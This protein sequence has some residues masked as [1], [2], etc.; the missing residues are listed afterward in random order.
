MISRRFSLVSFAF[1]AA[2]ALALGLWF[3][4]FQRQEAEATPPLEDLTVAVTSSPP[5]SSTLAAGGTVSY[6]VTVSADGTTTTG[7]VPLDIYLSGLTLVAGSVDPSAG[8]A[9]TEGTP[10]DCTVTTVFS[11]AGSRSVDFQATVSAGPGPAQV[12]AVLDTPINGTDDGVLTEE[13]NDANAVEDL[14]DANL[15]GDDG[16]DPGLDCTA[17]QEGTDAGGGPVEEPDNFDCT[18]HAVATGFDLTLTQAAAPLESVT[19]PTG[20]LVSYTLTVANSG[21]GTA[22]NVPIRDTLGTGLTLFGVVPGDGVTCSDVGPPEINCTATSIPAGQSRSVIVSAIVSATTGSV[23]NGASVDPNNVIGETNDDADDD[24][25]SCASVGEGTDLGG[26]TEPDNFDCTSHAVGGQIDLTIT[27]TASPASGNSVTTGSTIS[28]TLTA[29]ATGGT[30]SNVVIR[31]TPGTGL[32]F[33][34]MA[35][36]SGTAGTGVTCTDTSGPTYECT[37]S[38]I[39]SGDSRSAIVTVTVSATTGTVLNGATVDPANTIPEENEDADDPTYDCSSVGEQGDSGTATEE[40]NFECTSHTVGAAGLDLRVSKTASPADGSS[41]ASGGTITYT[42]TVTAANAAASNVAIR[43][44]VGTGLTIT[45]VTPGSGVT[46]SDTT[47]PEIN[48][49]A[50]SIASGSSVTVTV[51]ATVSAASGTVLNGA[52]VDPA[53]TITESNEDADDPSLDCSAVGEGSDA[54]DATEPDNFDC[55]SHTVGGGGAA[56]TRTLNLSPAGWHNFVWTGASGTALETAFSCI[57]GKFS[58]AYEWV[59][60]LNLFERYVPGNTLL[61]NM[62]PLTQYD[63]A[64]VLITAEGVTCVMPVVTP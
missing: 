17:V 23:L 32:T 57:S 12:G 47:G 28:Y 59:D 25:L 34:S 52:R 60:S 15:D 58:I 35:A 43:D 10:I 16:D 38:S 26:L 55:T 64:F 62:D 14:P 41:V 20:T 3:G 2:L 37:A 22:A 63:H 49:T 45:A 1:V 42:V 11:A 18:S 56:T 29:V 6:T 50:A 4:V 40:D 36:A 21:T 5:E 46:C 19:L 31:D 30:A 13:G 44:T 54:G 51:A 53:G 33:V 8:I 7:D 9:C 24:A 61:T 39:P 48:C 27:K